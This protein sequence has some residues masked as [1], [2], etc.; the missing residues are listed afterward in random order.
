M[1][2][3]RGDEHLQCPRTLRR[4]VW[5]GTQTISQAPALAAPSKPVDVPERLGAAG[6]DPHEEVTQLRSS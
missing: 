2:D 4:E 5:I 3:A 1:I 6:L